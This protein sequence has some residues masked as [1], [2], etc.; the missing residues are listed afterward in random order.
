MDSFPKFSFTGMGCNVVQLSHC[1]FTGH[2]KG[3]CFMGF[4]MTISLVSLDRG[5][6]KL[7]YMPFPNN[8]LDRTVAGPGNR[9]LKMIF[10]GP[11]DLSRHH[12][13]FKKCPVPAHV[14]FISLIPEGVLEWYKWNRSCLL[15]GL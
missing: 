14:T 6:S 7:N 9:L 2:M 3:N 1:Y 13:A 8:K 4:H 11:T 12:V 15:M 5:N 10:P